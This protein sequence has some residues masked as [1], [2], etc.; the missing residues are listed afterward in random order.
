MIISGIG[1]KIVTTSEI[2][3]ALA[4]S[5]RVIGLYTL[6][7][8]ASAVQ[9]NEFARHALSQLTTTFDSDLY[10][11]FINTC[12]THVITRS[13]VGGMI[14]ERAKVPRCSRVYDDASFAH[15][16]PFGDRGAISSNCTYYTTQIRVISKRL[17]G[18]N[19]EIADGNEWKRTLAVGPA[20]LQILEMVP[21]YDFITNNAVKQNLIT[22]M[23]YRQTNFDFIQAESARLVDSRLQ[24]CISG[25]QTIISSLYKSLSIPYPILRVRWVS[26]TNRVLPTPLCSAHINFNSTWKRNGVTVAGGNGPGTGTN[27]LNVPHAGGNG[28][29]KYPSDVILDKARDSL[30]ICDRG[31]KRIVRWFLRNANNGETIISGVTCKGL[32]M[33][34]QGFL[35]VSDVEKQEVRRWQVGETQGIVVAGGNGIGNRLDQLNDPRKVFVD[36]DHSVYVSEMVND[37]VMKWV[38]GA[39]EG[40]VV[41]GG[42]GR[43]SSLSQLN[44]PEG[45]IVD[46]LGTLYVAERG[47]NRIVRWPKG[48]TEGQIL[49]GESSAGSLQNQLFGPIGLSFDRHGN[50][51]VADHGNHRVQKFE[52]QLAA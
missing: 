38:K 43:G 9:L 4:L 3:K 40:I 52:I 13:L 45:I 39:R 7:I 35:Y 1:T 26:D 10:E 8:N 11:D 25:A 37:R 28:Q 20:L 29:L 42:R 46:Q 48:A 49:V 15:C 21:W 36:R 22:I 31:N 34:E 51:Y 2:L 27:Q 18:G 5:Q 50:L 19:V 16:I 33:D 41:A 30:F 44:L 17:L 14:E 6:T 12:G 32:T 23:R 24:P 47:N